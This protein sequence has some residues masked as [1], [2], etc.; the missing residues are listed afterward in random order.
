MSPCPHPHPP[1]PPAAVGRWCLV[2]SKG[3]E[4]NMMEVG[5]GMA[6]QK[7][8]AKAKP[9]CNITSDGKTLTIKAEG[10]MKTEQF[11]FNMGGKSEETIADGRKTQSVCTFTDGTLIK[12]QEWDETKST[13]TGK[14]EE[15]SGGMLHE[16]YHQYSGL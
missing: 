3:F 14:M 12:H 8:G 5:V 16:Q 11:S 1:R 2:E 9:N 4:E 13:I 6:L 7:M 10:T 15:I